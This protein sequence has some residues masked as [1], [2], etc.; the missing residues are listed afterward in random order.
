LKRNINN[1]VKRYTVL[2]D[3]ERLGYPIKAH[4]LIK[5]DK[6]SKIRLIA[7]LVKSRHVDNVFRTNNMYDL[8]IDAYF[9]SLNESE[10]FFEKLDNDYRIKRKETHYILNEFKCNGFMTNRY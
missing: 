10:E 7:E 3:Y 1:A 8:I 6:D 9:T 4:T 2:L 5:V